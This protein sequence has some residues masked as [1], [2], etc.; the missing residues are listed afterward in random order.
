MTVC[1]AAICENSM[2][3]GLADRMLSTGDVELQ[4]LQSKIIQLSN[5]MFAMY[6]GDV[7]LATELLT[8]IKATVANRI[9]KDPKNW[10][11]IVDVADLWREAYIKHKRTKAEA[12][13]LTP[14][15]LTSD[16]FISRQ[17]ELSN[18]FISQLTAELVNFVIP[19]VHVIFS[20]IDPS[21]PHLYLANNADITCWDGVGFVAIGSGSY[22]ARS[23][24]LFSGHTSSTT[25]TRGTAAIYM[26]KRRAEIAPG[27]GD[28]TDSA[29][30]LAIGQL[31]VI[32]DD[33]MKTLQDAT[34]D[35]LDKISQMFS[36]VEGKLSEKL[37][38]LVS[39]D[40]EAEATQQIVDGSAPTDTS[41]SR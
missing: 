4:P 15:G 21:G 24:M 10:W 32:R 34:Q 11:K 8:N 13:I 1:V 6:A 16:T 25:L 9:S 33:V 12:A 20:G 23:Q 35:E 17:K 18:G 30:L 29:L 27:V 14:L 7:A 2:I 22:H 19:D 5:S 26:A 28:H 41:S 39:A 31:S 40:S 36:I 38:K 37:T 3:V